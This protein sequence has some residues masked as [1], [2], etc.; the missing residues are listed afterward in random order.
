MS[1][2]CYLTSSFTLRLHIRACLSLPS[3]PSLSLS[4]HSLPSLSHSPL[5]APSLPSL[6]S[7][8]PLSPL[9]LLSLS[10]VR[11][12]YL[13]TGDNVQAKGFSKG[14]Y[15]VGKLAWAKGLDLLFQHM[16]FVKKRYGLDWMSCHV[17]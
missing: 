12:K 4:L 16:Q 7:L 8:S 15:F 1:S 13:T 6:L 3:L 14:A 2:S 5:T 10:G 17:M 11:D 9:S